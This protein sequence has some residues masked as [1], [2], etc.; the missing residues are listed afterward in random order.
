MGGNIISRRAAASML[1]E[2]ER[3]PDTET[4]GVILG[5]RTDKN[6]FMIAEAIDAGQNAVHEIGKLVCDIDSMNHMIKAVS[7]IY[8]TD[9][10]IIGVWHKH[11]NCCNPPFSDEDMKLHELMLAYGDHDILSVL[12][13]KNEN[14]DGYILRVFRFDRNRALTEEEF[15]INDLTNQFPYR[16]WF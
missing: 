1:S 8:E 4:G 6:D 11:N 10:E 2:I 5:I 16:K 14:G 15:E 3:Y 12:F 9:I 7:G 13:Q